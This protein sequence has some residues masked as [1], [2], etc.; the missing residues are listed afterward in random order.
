MNP[1]NDIFLFIEGILA[2]I[3][4]C[5]LPMIPVYLTYLVGQDQETTQMKLLVRNA[6]G[7]VLGFT[8]VFV[9]LGMTATTISRFLI[10][11]RLLIERIGGVLLIL[12][13][14]NMMGKLNIPFL[15]RDFRKA[16]PQAK[17]GMASSFLFGVIIAFGWS[18]CLGAFLGAALL[19]ASQADTVLLGGWKLLIFSLGLGVPFFITALLFHQ[20]THVFAAIKR[21]YGVISLVSGLFLIL[22]GILMAL[23]KFSLY[24]NIFY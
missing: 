19:Q 13:G 20:L 3:S 23:G 4:P 9:L 6:L 12:F 17:R 22:M 15:N 2:F 8:V 11:Q 21:H 5:F 18:P 7:F 16:L 14:L 24:T 10:H 1:A